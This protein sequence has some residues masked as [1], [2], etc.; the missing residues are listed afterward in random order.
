M[1]QD[2]QANKVIQVHGADRCAE[3]V[4]KT[5]DRYRYLCLCSHARIYEVYSYIYCTKTYAIINICAYGK[6]DLWR[7]TGE[8][9]LAS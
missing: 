5:E 3:W 9:S 4:D 1:Q 6:T 7:N 2:K 8:L